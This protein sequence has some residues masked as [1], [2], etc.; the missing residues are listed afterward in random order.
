[1]FRL[2]HD[3]RSKEFRRLPEVIFWRFSV[4]FRLEVWPFHHLHYTHKISFETKHH[5]NSTSLTLKNGFQPYLRF[6]LASP[7]HLHRLASCFLLLWSLDHSPTLGSLLPSLQA[8]RWL[9]GEI[10]HMAPWLWCRNQ[11]LPNYLSSTL[12]DVD[13]VGVM[14]D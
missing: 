9:L 13:Y 5:I 2:R 12:N 11:R 6:V 3:A 7:S 10:H 8:V 4:P 1:M 14:F